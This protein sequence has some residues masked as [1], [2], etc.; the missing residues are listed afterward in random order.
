MKILL[1]AWKMIQNERRGETHVARH[2]TGAGSA[3]ILV[4]EPPKPATSTNPSKR[5]RERLNGE[6][7]M[8]ALLLPYDPTT[9]SRL[10]KLSVLRLAV[11]FLQCKAHFQA[12]MHSSSFLSP[13]PM[14][15]HAFAYNPQPPAPYSSKVP[16]VFDV[17][18]S[19]ALLDAEESDFE[20][21]SLKALGGF[22]LVINDN[23]EIYYA[24]E[25]VEDFL[26]FHQSDI[27]HQPLYD[28]IHSE[29]RDDIRQQ[30][31]VNFHMP[32][33]S[34][35][36]SDL[37]NPENLKYLERNA[38]ARFRCLLDNTCGFLRIDIRGKLMSLHG[39]PSS[40]VMGRSNPGA[41]LGLIAV[42]TPFVPPS[43]SE[44]SSED[45][46]LKTKHH[47]DGALVS[48]DQKVYE[49]LE[50]TEADLPAPL[51]QLVHVEDAVCMAEAHK[52]VIKNGSS[53]LLV[54]R[55]V[56]KKTSRVYFVQSSCRMFYKNG[57]PESIGLTHRLLSEVE[58]TTLLEKRSSLKAKLL[59]FDDSFLQSPRNLQSTAALPL[60]IAHS[61][62]E[63][64]GSSSEQ[65][66]TDLQ[67]ACA[68]R[69]KK[70]KEENGVNPLAL[71]PTA[72]I[73]APKIYLDQWR[74]LPGPF[75]LPPFGVPTALP[76]EIP[77]HPSEAWGADSYL[78]Y[79]PHIPYPPLSLTHCTPYPEMSGVAYQS[80][81]Q[82]GITHS[83]ACHLNQPAAVHD[84]VQPVDHAAKQPQEYT[85][86][87]KFYQ[88]AQPFS[89]TDGS[90]HD[91]LQ[92]N[93]PSGFSLIS[94]QRC[95][96]EVIMTAETGN[97]R[98]IKLT[99]SDNEV[100]DVPRDVI[101]LSNTINTLL[102]DLGL[103]DSE[104]DT[105]EAIPVSNVS[106]PIL[107]KV[108]QWC[109]HH[110]EDPLPTEDSDNREKRTDDIN[111]W[112]VEFLKVDQ[113]TLFELILAANY[114]DIKGLLDVT[115]KTVAN[116]IKGKSPEEIRRTFNIK[117]DFTPEEEE[118]IRKEKRLY[119]Q[120]SPLTTSKSKFVY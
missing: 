51:Y 113:G 23:G 30:I 18:T 116:M 109:Q 26:G 24:S 22:I 91:A 72:I 104:E 110:R 38:N 14:A 62:K 61:V 25:N 8:V 117:N 35:S 45:L 73:P 105:T 74:V 84:P 12:C 82:Y 6:L 98:K 103:D 54:Y 93:H 60:P 77:A 114:L 80:W 115:C 102:Q 75:E 67:S 42:C 63:N 111:S 19:S 95:P 68:P 3:R 58:G 16:T 43:T 76:G 37:Y 9:I 41:V 100:F 69:L 106:S 56:S 65:Y 83:E 21:I 107:K 7:E 36:H 120:F 97:E 55:L 44:V 70:R 64:E 87:S 96:V 11:S 88:Y 28:L 59:S 89:V 57:K 112:D 108:I 5:H 1:S 90:V 71:A 46:I 85:E 50:L 34:N 119:F 33:G 92:S 48:M 4:R 15:T 118:Q 53:G 79:S 13:Y 94:E 32:S 27:L 39:L 29:D 17:R 101:R 66:S 78:N 20:L 49:M 47:L 86:N 31:D 81:Q 99:S 10:D 2:L 40:Y 52:E